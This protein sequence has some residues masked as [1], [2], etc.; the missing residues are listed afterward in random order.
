VLVAVA[1]AVSVRQVLDPVLAHNAPYLPFAVALMLT[2]RFAGRGPALLATALST[3]SVA[4]FFLE[5]R[6]SF[7]IADPAAATS[8]ALFATIGVGVSL[9]TSHLRDSM[10]EIA[11]QAAT[12][13]KQSQLI[14]LSHDAIITLD[15]NQNVT[16]WNAGALE[17][18]GRTESEAIGKGIHDLLQTSGQIPLP[19]IDRILDRDGRW[20]GQLCHTARDGRTITTESR[21]VLIRG[22]NGTPTGML[23]IN[24]DVTGRIRIT[25]ELARAKETAETANRA[26]SEFLANMSHEIRTPMNGVIGTAD[27]LLQTVLSSEQRQYAEIIR[28]C[29]ESLL[30]LLDDILDLSKIEAGRLSIETIPFDLRQL[31]KQTVAI[32]DL[33][34]SDKGL[35]LTFSFDDQVPT[36]VAGD[37]VRLRQVLMNLLTNA[38]KFTTEG[39]VTLRVTTISDDPGAV[40]IRVEV[41]DTG[42]GLAPEV[43]VRLFQPFT[44]GDASTTRRFGGT[45]LG[46]AISKRLVELMGGTIG[47]ESTLGKGSVFWFTITL[48]RTGTPVTAPP[49]FSPVPRSTELHVLLVEDNPV[50][51]RVTSR[52]LERLG[53][54][55][56]IAANGQ[57][58]LAHAAE[59]R[60]DLVLMDCHMPE[61]DGYEATQELRRRE[62]GRDRT[63]V[64]A[65]TAGAF[66]SDRE[67]AAV[68]GMD[69]YLSKPVK[70]ADIARTLHKW[71]KRPSS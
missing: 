14:D 9:L 20:D 16:G 46:L 39:T 45:G 3:L 60:Y 18:Y 11:S 6:H 17:L 65:L 55:V 64:I 38:V 29:G 12:V 66:E 31:L 67:R 4:W 59:T 48:P 1:A 34:A 30:R 40:T 69:D 5:P 61:M 43:Q 2:G 13:C 19:E 53:C 15:A 70:L 28:E 24:R 27:L 62:T 54:R 47:L 36:G 25:D 33:L 26:K 63:P 56:A 32:V 22:A 57:D 8:L 41:R 37:P 52:I 68:A 51:Q 7:A 49:A 44:Q 58:A 50:N 42:P 10:M 35:Q 71:T 23:Q 21:Q